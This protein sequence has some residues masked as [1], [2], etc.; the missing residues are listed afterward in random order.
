MALYKKTHLRLAPPPAPPAYGEFER[1]PATFQVR[2]FPF[3]HHPLVIY[4]RFVR[5]VTGRAPEPWEI[6]IESM[7]GPQVLGIDLD[8]TLT[9]QKGIMLTY[10]QHIQNCVED[11]I[12]N[13]YGGPYHIFRDHPAKPG[14]VV[15]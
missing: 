1:Y 9:R 10:R 6:A 4:F 3:S 5:P 2:V 8:H 7:N 13:T 15:L 14:I 11:I 12:F